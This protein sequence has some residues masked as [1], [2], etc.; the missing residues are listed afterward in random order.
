MLGDRL[1]K[2]V[3]ETDF[4]VFDKMTKALSSRSEN[5]D[6][7][8]ELAFTK[9]KNLFAKKDEEFSLEDKYFVAIENSPTGEVSEKTIFKYH[10]K[11][12]RIWAE[13]SGGDIIQGFLIGTIDDRKNLHFSYQHLNSKNEVKSGFCTSTPEILS[14]GK[15]LFHE[16]WQW[17]SGEKGY[18][19]IK[20]L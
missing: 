11:E 7:N 19:I 12:H 4:V 14:N 17:T 5:W 10:Q 1:F 20:E 16:N 2:R 8:L 6:K 9:G 15:L 18:S 3:K 13:Y